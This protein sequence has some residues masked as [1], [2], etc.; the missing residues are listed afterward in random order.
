MNEI[1]NLKNFNKK[2]LP[3]DLQN[4]EVSFKSTFSTIKI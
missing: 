2:I 4:D 1:K 3:S